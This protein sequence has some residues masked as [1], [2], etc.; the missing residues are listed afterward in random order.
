MAGTANRG[1]IHHGR[2][3]VAGS[4]Q[5]N[6]WNRSNTMPVFGPLTPQTWQQ[7][8]SSNITGPYAE[9]RIRGDELFFIPA[10]S[11][12]LDVAFEYVSKNWVSTSIATTASAW[13]NDADTAFLDEQLMTM[14]LV[15]R[16]KQAKG[17]DYDE[18]FVKYERRVMDAM[19]RDGSKPRIDCG[20]NM[21]MLG[22]RVPEGSW[23]VP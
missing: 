12:G 21:P 23:N 8:K 9:Y 16:F 17:F 3:R 10:P 5:H 20:N 7:R 22:L 15:W 18:D 19:A 11:A 13:T 1:D 14:G 6:R 4:R 2:S